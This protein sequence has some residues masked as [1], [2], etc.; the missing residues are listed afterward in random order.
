MYKYMNIFIKSKIENIHVPVSFKL[1]KK[2]EKTAFYSLD[3]YLSLVSPTRTHLTIGTI[4]PVLPVDIR[5][6]IFRLSV[7]ELG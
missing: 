2:F 5:R 7:T 4:Y 3:G 6:T 1:I